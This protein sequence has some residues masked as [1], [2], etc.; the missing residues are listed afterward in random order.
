MR[1]WRPRAAQPHLDPQSLPLFLGKMGEAAGQQGDGIPPSCAFFSRAVL[2]PVPRRSEGF[3]NPSVLGFVV[4]GR[5]NMCKAAA[6]RQH[7]SENRR[8][9]GQ[10]L[11]L[12]HLCPG[13]FNPIDPLG[14]QRDVQ[15]VTQLE[16][17]FLQAVLA[18][19]VTE[20]RSRCSPRT[21]GTLDPYCCGQNEWNTATVNSQTHTTDEGPF[22]PNGTGKSS[23]INGNLT[24]VGNSS[25][26]LY[27]D[28]SA[29]RR[30]EKKA[31]DAARPR[32]LCSL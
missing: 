30:G 14:Y 3:Y 20:R 19:F 18:P 9:G 22:R 28:G 26:S 7:Y 10:A 29:A 16:R 21:F 6:V 13:Q 15:F 5:F 12:Y 4:E 11:H 25:E 17:L 24:A 8:H 1:Q 32:C 23:P 2:W 27:A 31:A